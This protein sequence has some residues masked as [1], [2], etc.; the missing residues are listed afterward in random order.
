MIDP[1]RLIAGTIG[2]YGEAQTREMYGDIVPI[3][4]GRVIAG[5]GGGSLGGVGEHEAGG[6]EGGSGA[7]EGLGVEEHVH[8][9]RLGCRWQCL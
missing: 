3:D 4:A 9:S 1:G 8:G 2:V 6:E 7:D 5:G